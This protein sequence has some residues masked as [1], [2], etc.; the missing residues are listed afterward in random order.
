MLWSKKCHP[1]ISLMPNGM[2]N[3]FDTKDYAYFQHTWKMSP[4]CLV[5]CRTDWSYIIS[6]KKWMALK[7]AGYYVV[8]QLE[9][10]TST[11]TW[12]GN[13]LE[14]RLVMLAGYM[15]QLMSEASPVSH[16]TEARPCHEY[17]VLV[18]CLAGRQTRLQQCSSSCISSTSC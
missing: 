10:Q 17:G 5:K 18:H 7:T 2:L 16:G 9:F 11:F 1:I 6:P 15:S 12:Y 13:Q 8:Q 14:F 3:K 4:H